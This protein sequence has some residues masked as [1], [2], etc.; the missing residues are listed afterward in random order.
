MESG[1]GRA[2]AASG[3]KKLG[4]ICRLDLD[5]VEKKRVRSQ[6]WTAVTR[7]WMAPRAMVVLTVVGVGL[8]GSEA[9]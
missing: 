9:C 2:G 7:R 4:C 8:T 1:S 6:T 5:D 3:E